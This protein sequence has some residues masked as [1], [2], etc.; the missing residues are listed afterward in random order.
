M[1]FYAIN[2]NMNYIFIPKVLSYSLKNKLFKFL[3]ELNNSK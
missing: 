2:I 3:F 1:T